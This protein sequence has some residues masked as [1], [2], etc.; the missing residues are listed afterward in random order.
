MPDTISYKDGYSYALTVEAVDASPSAIV[1]E[2]ITLVGVKDGASA[3]AD[4]AVYDMSDCSVTIFMAEQ[5][6]YNKYYYA[7]IN[8]ETYELK[9]EEILPA[10]LGTVSLKSVTISDDNTFADIS[11][12]NLNYE[13]SYLVNIMGK[14]SEGTTQASASICVEPEST[15]TVRIEGTDLDK[16]TWSIEYTQC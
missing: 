1:P 7:T 6:S 16:L 15:E 9:T 5:E 12:N 14:D 8:G 3:E 13:L 2:N 4:Y 10:A 11:V